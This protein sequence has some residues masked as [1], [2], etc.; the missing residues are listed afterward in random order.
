MCLAMAGLV[1]LCA[2]GCRK[3]MLTWRLLVVKVHEVK[4]ISFVFVPAPRIPVLTLLPIIL[5]HVYFK[6]Q[7]TQQ[8]AVPF[9]MPWFMALTV[10][11]KT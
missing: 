5:P 4:L 1:G 7:S 8:T 2:E 6:F 9:F 3:V 10:K 11:M